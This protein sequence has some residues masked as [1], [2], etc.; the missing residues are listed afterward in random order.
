MSYPPVLT[1]ETS[2]LI[3]EAKGRFDAIKGTLSENGFSV[4]QCVLDGEGD[5]SML[6]EWRKDREITSFEE[7]RCKGFL[8]WALAEVARIQPTL[9]E[10]ELASLHA[11][12]LDVCSP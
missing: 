9:T 12:F 1:A 2:A 4:C 7:Q 10:D 5:I 11:A 6:S 3:Q 8:T